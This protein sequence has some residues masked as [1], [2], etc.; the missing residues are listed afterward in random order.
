MLP[1]IIFCQLGKTIPLY[2]QDAMEQARLFNP[3]SPVILL[4]DAE[5][6][7]AEESRYSRIKAEVVDIR[8]IPQSK[9]H[10]EF[11]QLS[12]LPQ[13]QPSH[14]WQTTTERLYVLEDYLE[15]Q[16]I[17]E[18][19]HI[20]SDCLLYQNLGD[21]LSI[22]RKHYPGL[23]ATPMSPIHLT[24]SLFYVRN[25]KQLADFTTE[26]N[27]LLALGERKLKEDFGIDRPGDMTL[28]WMYQYL[29]G[30]KALGS[31]PMAPDAPEDWHIKDFGC[32]YDGNPWG[33][34]IGGITS[35]PEPGYYWEFQVIGT[36]LKNRKYKIL[37]RNDSQGR[38]IPRVAFRTKLNHWT[39]YRFCKAWPFGL[40]HVHNKK[41]ELYRSF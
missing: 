27:R 23:A 19:F 18:V 11:L 25:R 15:R 3:E 35:K 36:R 9:N 17:D 38:K 32:L 8:S 34:Y 40:L 5:I 14:F 6:S 31:L 26:A 16:K 30:Q 2:L 4:T 41:T 39:G 37:W 7:Q 29:H 1:P 22:F 28:L 20:E 33:Q 24:A 13:Y 21:Y 12:F 10:Q